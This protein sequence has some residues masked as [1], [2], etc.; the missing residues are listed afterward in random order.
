MSSDGQY[1]RTKLRECEGLPDS[2]MFIVRAAIG[3]NDIDNKSVENCICVLRNLSYACQEVDDEKYLEKR[4]QKNKNQGGKGKVI[5]FF[6]CF[7][8][9][10]LT[11]AVLKY[12]DIILKTKWFSR[13]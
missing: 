6:V 4:N 3:K 7:T 8:L 10:Y 11:I 13:F 9:I 5:T 2:L 12:S 1:A